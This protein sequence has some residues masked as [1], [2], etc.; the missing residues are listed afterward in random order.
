MTVSFAVPSH[1]GTRIDVTC[2]SQQPVK[3][4]PE[5]GSGLAGILFS[6]DNSCSGQAVITTCAGVQSRTATANRLHLTA[7]SRLEGLAGGGI[8]RPPRALAS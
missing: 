2:P 4:C 5:N 7:S 3:A 6:A 1:A 8:E